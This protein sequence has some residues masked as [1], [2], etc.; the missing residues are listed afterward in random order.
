L[1]PFPSSLK[2]EAACST[3]DMCQTANVN[4]VRAQNTAVCIPLDI[5][6]DRPLLIPLKI[7]V[8]QDFSL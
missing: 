2:V 4:S 6:G 7:L 8:A 3:K 5:R 1:G